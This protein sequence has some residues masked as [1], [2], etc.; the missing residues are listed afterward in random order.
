MSRESGDELIRVE[1]PPAARATMSP[2]GRYV[3]V[4]PEDRLIAIVDTQTWT[5]QE[6]DL[7]FGRMRG[8]AFSP[9][10]SMLAIA[11]ENEI[12]IIDLASVT[13]WL[14]E[15]RTSRTCRPKVFQGCSL[16]A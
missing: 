3:A 14:R 7:G 2:D 13:H 10:S 8:G 6:L 5:T 16:P 1:I 9:D 15:S 11:D 12:L 4:R